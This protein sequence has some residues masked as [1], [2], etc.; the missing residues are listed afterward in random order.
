MISRF[1]L[2]NFQTNPMIIVNFFTFV[3]EFWIAPRISIY[4]DTLYRNDLL[5][6][7][8][9]TSVGNSKRI[10]A[11]EVKISYDKIYRR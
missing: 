5:L 7:N 4:I 6:H 10:K 2:V 1:I 8:G 11:E 9:L 3:H